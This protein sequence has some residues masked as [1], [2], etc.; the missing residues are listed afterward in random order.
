MFIQSVSDNVSTIR[1]K[2]V[3]LAEFANHPVGFCVAAI[4][5][6]APDHLFIQRVAVDP[7]ARRRGAGLALLSAAARDRPDKHIAGATLDDDAST[8][9]LNQKLATS[10][11]ENLVVTPRRRFTRTDL[12]L[13]AGEAHRPWV[14]TRSEDSL[15]R[16]V[17]PSS[18]V[19]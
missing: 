3:L 15:T 10:L 7:L 13:A 2:L 19:A 5:R 9:A 11:G 1:K 8:H 6:Y 17:E 16:I 4:G 18:T 14:I 12:S